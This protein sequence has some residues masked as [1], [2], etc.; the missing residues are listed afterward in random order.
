M[1]SGTLWRTAL[2]TTLATSRARSV[3]FPITSYATVA[4]RTVR[5]RRRSRPVRPPGRRRPGPAARPRSSRR[6]RLAAPGPAPANLRGACRPGRALLQLAG[7]D[8]HFSRGLRFAQ[9][10][11]DGRAHHGQRR[12]QFV[13]GVGHETALGLEGCFEPPSSPSM[14]SPRSFSSSSGPWTARRSLQVLLGDL[15]AVAVIVRNGRSTRPAISHPSP[16]ETIAIM[17]RAMADTPSRLA[18]LVRRRQGGQDL[19]RPRGCTGSGPGVTRELPAGRPCG[20]PSHSSGGHGRLQHRAESWRTARPCG[21]AGDGL[22]DA[23]R[24]R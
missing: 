22:H 5:R 21:L 18:P 15:R 12:A 24:W 3:S 2:V 16:I 20:L 6:G 4:S 17:P 8:P 1:P 14:V 13:R 9:G 10:H 23:R 11:V 7:Q 19:T